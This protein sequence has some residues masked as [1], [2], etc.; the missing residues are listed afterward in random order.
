MLMTILEPF[1]IF[2]S[3]AIF[4]GLVLAFA[5]K[6]FYVKVDERIENIAKLFPGANCGGCGFPGCL[7]Y[8]SAIVEK[9][10]DITL[11][12]PGGKEVVQKIAD[13][14]G[15]TA[16]NTTK[17][18]VVLHC[19]S[20]GHDNTIF[21]YDYIGVENCLAVTLLG[22][23]INMCIYGCV[24]RNTCVAACKYGAIIVDSNNMRSIDRDKCMG[25]S[26]C[27][28]ACP[29]DLI[30]IVSIENHVHI[31][32]SSKDKGAVA[33]RFCGAKT[34]C[35]GCGLCA[36]NCPVNAIN[37]ENNLAVIDYSKCTNCGVCVE[38]CMTKAIINF[39]KGKTT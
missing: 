13:I 9:D 20:G 3:L 33:K 21:K 10:H 34:A 8:A 1:L 7:G 32:C 27:V 38:K 36:K 23:G 19:N 17:K 35:I 15:K 5:S 30:E 39:S 22:G 29:R 24:G 28:K 16:T 6:F 2:G 25:C 14:L 37:M 11:C 26:A 12:G 18:V 4:F 31:N